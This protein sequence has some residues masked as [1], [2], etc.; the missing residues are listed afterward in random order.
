MV[1]TRQPMQPEDDSWSCSFPDKL[2]V[3]RNDCRF[4]SYFKASW[5]LRKQGVAICREVDS[6]LN[7]L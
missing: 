2:D 4:M 7:H 1:T 3:C 5:L 6:V